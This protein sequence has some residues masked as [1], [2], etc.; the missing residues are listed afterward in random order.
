MI[1]IKKIFC[2]TD[3]SE[4]SLEALDTARGLAVRFGAELHIMHCAEPIPV[5]TTPTAQIGMPTETMDVSGYQK[6]IVDR[7]KES[8]E[9]LAKKHA[10]QDVKVQI[11]LSE[12]KP[13][14][15]IVMAAKEIGADLMV[16]SS[17]GTSGLRRFIFGSVADKIIRTS[18]CPV[19]TMTPEQ[20]GD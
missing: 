8:L 14:N 1:T 20:E 2:P 15:E 16:I 13:Q 11:H 4:P 18:P 5:P 12:G 9:E 3:F 7:A 19:L 17:H 6:H 10:N